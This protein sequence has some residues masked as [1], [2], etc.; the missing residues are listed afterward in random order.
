MS[1]RT[2]RARLTSAEDFALASHDLSRR[3]IWLA[4]LEWR[5]FHPA[6]LK[7]SPCSVKTFNGARRP[8]TSPEQNFVAMPTGGESQG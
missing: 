3:G 2:E 4:D 8:A 7:H 1:E 5:R 6:T